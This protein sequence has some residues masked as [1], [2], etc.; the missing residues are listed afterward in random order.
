MPLNFGSH[1]GSGKVGVAG[2]SA[3]KMWRGAAAGE[4]GCAG[5]HGAGVSDDA[6]LPTVP[7]GTPVAPGPV[8]PPGPLSAGA[9]E[10]FVV[11]KHHASARA[12]TNKALAAR[13]RHALSAA[14]PWTSASLGLRYVALVLRR[15]LH[16]DDVRSLPRATKVPC[17]LRRD[18]SRRSTA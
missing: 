17:S 12:V 3:I 6:L 4:M 2:R 7:I 15:S 5:G 16:A 14:D 13:S 10:R 8:P 9:V 18:N 11:Q 1:S